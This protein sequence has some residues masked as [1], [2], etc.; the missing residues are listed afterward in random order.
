MP[1]LISDSEISYF[2]EGGNQLY[3]NLEPNYLITD[4]T[5]NKVHS[6]YLF[7]IMMHLYIHNS[8]FLG[9]LLLFNILSAFC[10][11]SFTHQ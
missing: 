1:N 10:V 2:I 7:V 5:L 9:T 11:C 6:K 8:E 4:I 3:T